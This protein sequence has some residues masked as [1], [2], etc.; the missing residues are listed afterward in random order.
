MTP[1]AARLL[2]PCRTNSEPIARVFGRV[3]TKRQGVWDGS[4][5]E[6]HV[7]GFDYFR[8]RECSRRDNSC[9]LVKAVGENCYCAIIQGS[10]G[11]KP[12]RGARVSAGRGFSRSTCPCGAASKR[13]QRAGVRRWHFWHAPLPSL[14][15]HPAS[16]LACFSAACKG[17]SRLSEAPPFSLSA[18]AELY[19]CWK[20]DMPACLRENRVCMRA[21]KHVEATRRR[22]G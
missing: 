2:R 12:L 10:G 7:Q 16:C 8:D 18:S 17:A 11:E 3:E 20:P 22:A 14:L 13:C 5:A 4:C 21:K 15:H 19:V 9:L 1:R 6:M